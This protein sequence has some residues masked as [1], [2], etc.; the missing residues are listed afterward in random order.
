MQIWSVAALQ[1]TIRAAAIFPV[2]PNRSVC[3]ELRGCL[4]CDSADVSHAPVRSSPTFSSGT[5]Q[6]LFRMRSRAAI[7]NTDVFSY[8]VSKDGS[9]FIVNR[10]VKPSSVPPLDILLNATAS[11][12]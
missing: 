1:H 6:P 5:A 2:G 9:R 8:D 3:Q 4:T 10:Y 11:A 12:R 7:S